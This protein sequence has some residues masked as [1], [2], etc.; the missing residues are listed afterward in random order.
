MWGIDR[1]SA[2]IVAM[3]GLTPAVLAQAPKYEVVT[4]S[5]TDPVYVRNGTS[6]SSLIHAVG[7]EGILGRASRFSPNGTT[8]GLDPWFFDGTTTHIL[9]LSGSGYEVASSGGVFRTSDVANS[10]VGGVIAG[11]TQRFAPTGGSLGNDAWVFRNGVTQA[12]PGRDGPYSYLSG[13]FARRQSSSVAPLGSGGDVVGRSARYTSSGV[14]RGFDAWV[15]RNGQYINVGLTGSLY[16]LDDQPGQPVRRNSSISATNAQ[17]IVVG[18][19]DMFATPASSG[20]AFYFD[21]VSTQRINPI[22][23]AYERTAFGRFVRNVSNTE[24]RLDDQGRAFG[25]SERFTT[26]GQSNG[27]DIWCFDG[28]TTR[29]I[30]LTGTGFESSNADGSIRRTSLLTSINASGFAIGTSIRN[31]GAASAAWRSDGTTTVAIGLDGPTYRDSTSQPLPS[32][33]LSMSPNGNVVGISNRNDAISGPPVD[34]WMFN[35]AS[36]VRINPVRPDEGQVTNSVRELVVNDAGF[37]AGTMSFGNNVQ[38]V[39]HFDGTTSRWVNLVGGVY[40]LNGWREAKL[41]TSTMRPVAPLSDNGLL[42]GSST[43]FSQA[44]NARN[45]NTAWVFDPATGITHELLMSQ[46]PTTLAA[47]SAIEYM[48]PQGVALGSY[49]LY[50]PSGVELGYRAFYWSLSTGAIDLGATVPGGLDAAGWANLMNMV[51]GNAQN[52]FNAYTGTGFGIEPQRI[53]GVGDLSNGISGV[54]YML[55]AVPTPSSLLAFVGIGALSVRR[56]RRG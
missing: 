18:V 22:G 52:R 44:T 45:G 7:T 43:R 55:V 21:G 31:W 48:T 2:F 17:G 51:S 28:T 26:T 49:L 46:N 10:V 19:S 54:T 3:A 41:A 9:G 32:A 27:Q 33:P 4:V 24:L 6:S 56:R 23:A 38:D 53:Y 25:G 14:N 29:I 50:S 5:P 30:G 37:A 35:G 20:D 8:V 36:T 40:E 47:S 13:G 15:Y 39:F 1:R 11:T 16:E 34:A 12:L 42:A